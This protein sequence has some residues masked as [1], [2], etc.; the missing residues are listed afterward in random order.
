MFLYFVKKVKWKLGKE[1]DKEEEELLDKNREEGASGDFVAICPINGKRLEIPLVSQV[2]LCLYRIKP[3]IKQKTNTYHH[4]FSSKTDQSLPCV[5]STWNSS[6]NS[7]KTYSA[8]SGP[9]I[10]QS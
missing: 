8:L 3:T 5:R 6:R 4:Y 10:Y 2:I 1:G 7:F 9:P